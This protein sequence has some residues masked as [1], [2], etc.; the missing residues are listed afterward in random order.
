MSQSRTF[1][2]FFSGSQN[3]MRRDINPS[4]FLSSHLELN[5]R[6]YAFAIEPR[7]EKPRFS[8]S[9]VISTFILHCLDSIIPLLAISKNSRLQLA[10]EAEQAGLSLPWSKTPKTGFVVSWL[11][12]FLYSKLSINKN[13]FTSSGHV[14]IDRFVLF[15]SDNV[16]TLGS[17]KIKRLFLHVFFDLEQKFCCSNQISIKIH[18]LVSNP[19][20][21]QKSYLYATEKHS[22]F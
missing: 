22:Y 21:C 17:I 11:N 20:I 18:D 14:L 1:P 2:D 15:A 19:L 5:E 8:H 16:S 3:I 12:F 10:S 7:N 9:S 4:H 6:G 13:L